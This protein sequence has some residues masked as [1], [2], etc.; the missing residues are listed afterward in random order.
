MKWDVG[1]EPQTQINGDSCGESGAPGNSRGESGAPGN[2]PQ[3]DQGGN[4]ASGEP[5]P[6]PLP[7]TEAT[8]PDAPPT[9]GETPGASEPARRRRGFA[10]MDRGRVAEIARKGGRAAH[11][12]GTAHEFTSEEARV[13]GRRG[14][15]ATHANR[16]LARERG[17]P[18]Q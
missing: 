14:G 15:R 13:A 5:L 17:T 9:Q 12:A 10:V 8:A 18:P 7:A 2:E 3:R 6:T 1:D 16:R 4:D 11:A